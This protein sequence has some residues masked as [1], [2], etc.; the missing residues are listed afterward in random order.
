MVVAIHQPMYLPWLPYFG[1][2]AAADVFVFFDD[3]QYPRSR[4]FFNRNLVK[5]PQGSLYLTVPVTGKGDKPLVH[6]VEIDQS[7]QWQSR[8]WR[9]VS[10][11]YAKAAAF[12]RYRD[13]LEQVFSGREW[14]RLADLNI[15]LI[16]LMSSFFGIETMLRRSSELGVSRRLPA[17]QQIVEIVKKVGGDVYLSGTGEGSRRTVEEDRFED[18]DIQVRWF[19]CETTEYPQLWGDFLPN[20]SALDLLLNCGGESFKSVVQTGSSSAFPRNGT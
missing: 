15:A 16:E 7:Q 9:T 14:K 4:S 3:V 19:S 2:V 18:E 12:D 20:L 11:N 10:H 5:T 13:E 6:E 1:K 8:H 17:P